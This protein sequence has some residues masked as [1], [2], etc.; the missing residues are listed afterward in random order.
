[1]RRLLA[2]LT[3]AGALLAGTVAHPPPAH[4]FCFIICGIIPLPGGG[5]I[6]QFPG[7]VCYQPSVDV[8]ISPFC[9]PT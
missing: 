3:L 5:Y 6:L 9:A 4:A 1:M 7:F 8:P 2:T